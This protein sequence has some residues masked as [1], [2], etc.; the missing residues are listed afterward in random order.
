M[1]KDGTVNASMT[2]LHKLNDPVHGFLDTDNFILCILCKALAPDDM[3]GK[4]KVIRVVRL[5]RER[6][7]QIRKQ[8]GSVPCKIVQ[9][10]K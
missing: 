6:Q 8:K 7:L 3:A 5:V 10:S 9:G 4:N 1:I 2:R